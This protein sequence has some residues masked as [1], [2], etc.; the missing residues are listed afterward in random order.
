MGMKTLGLEADALRARRD[1]RFRSASN[2]ACAVVLQVH[3]VDQHRDLADAEQVEQ[4]AVAAG[5]L[6]HAFVGID[7]Q[8][9][10][11]G[12]GGAG[13]HVLQE[14]LVARARR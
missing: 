2:R 7:Q 3:L 11:L 12:V 10:R 1:I 8:Q 4:V 5:V 13:D 14:F 9:R 6:L